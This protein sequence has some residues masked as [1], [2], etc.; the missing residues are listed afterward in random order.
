MKGNRERVSV[1]EINKAFTDF[2]GEKS[3]E[4]IDP[5][6]KSLAAGSVLVIGAFFIVFFIGRKTGSIRST[7]F[8]IRRL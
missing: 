7:F 3:L 1:E 5:S 2:F 4:K 6:L 8:E